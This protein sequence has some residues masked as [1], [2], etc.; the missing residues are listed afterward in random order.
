M[1]E[2]L[3]LLKVL[4]SQCWKS[5]QLADFRE[6][7]KEFVPVRYLGVFCLL[8]SGFSLCLFLVNAVG[9]RCLICTIHCDN[10]FIDY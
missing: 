8:S 6:K 9:Y 5:D 1:S 4:S 7:K 2:L 3:R 10:M